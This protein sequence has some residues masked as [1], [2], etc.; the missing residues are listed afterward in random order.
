MTIVRKYIIG[1]FILLLL[2]ASF[3]G[4]YILYRRNQT[5]LAL[6]AKTSIRNVPGDP[7][8]LKLTQ[9][10]YDGIHGRQRVVKAHE[11]GTLSVH[12]SDGWRL[13]LDIP[14]GALARDTTVQLTPLFPDEDP[15]TLD[16]GFSITPGDLV[17]RKPV[18]VT[19]RRESGTKPKSNPTPETLPVTGPATAYRLQPRRG[20]MELQMIVRSLESPTTIPI[21]ITGGGIYGVSLKSSRREALAR[22]TLAE[23]APDTY[24]VLEA[25]SFLI[26]N[27]NSL[28]PGEL[29]SVTRAIE[30]ILDTKEFDPFALDAA[31]AIS[32]VLKLDLS[33]KREDLVAICAGQGYTPA[34]IHT[35]GVTAARLG[36]SDLQLSCTGSAVFRMRALAQS[37][38][39]PEEDEGRIASHANQAALLGILDEPTIRDALLARFATQVASIATAL[40]REERT[41]LDRG[42]FLLYARI[43]PDGSSRTPN[44]REKAWFVSE[45]ESAPNGFATYADDFLPALQPVEG[46]ERA[47]MGQAYALYRLGL[48]ADTPDDADAIRNAMTLADGAQDVPPHLASLCALLRGFGANSPPYCEGHRNQI[49][50]AEEGLR[51]SGDVASKPF[52][53]LA[54]PPPPSLTPEPPQQPQEP[55]LNSE[56]TGW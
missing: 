6:A 38:G 27:G 31:A 17:F 20:I 37:V 50:A 9:P 52:L 49:Q 15:A 12:T 25:G 16:T 46:Y 33:L 1:L 18:L 8:D 26:G 28:S 30:T 55:S 36:Y 32:T 34:E 29:T 42:R 39:V 41:I 2:A 23:P 35:A 7:D 44:A 54:T 19:Y 14:A 3:Y 48:E 4:A 10:R 11:G 43:A 13:V 40:D 21:R 24:R 5:P 53:P 22:L 56:T 47:I 45:A 51:A